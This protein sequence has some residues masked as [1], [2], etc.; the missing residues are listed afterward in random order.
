VNP[1]A[2]VANA[3][4]WFN[5]RSRQWWVTVGAVA[6]LVAVV[7][8]ATWLRGLALDYAEASRPL[9]I[10]EAPAQPAPVREAAPTAGPAC[11]NPFGDAIPYELS[12]DARRM[13]G[14]TLERPADPNPCVAFEVAW[15]LLLA[16]PPTDVRAGDKLCAARLTTLPDTTLD[17]TFDPAQGAPLVDCT[18]RAGQTA[19]V[20]AGGQLPTVTTAAAG[21][22]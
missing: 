8:V 1:L 19:Q 6:G 21:G 3:R 11:A 17:V 9:T 13:I 12:P 10:E 7:V 4:R 5:G 20:P 2:N 15:R 18:T 14:G 22:Q 16:V